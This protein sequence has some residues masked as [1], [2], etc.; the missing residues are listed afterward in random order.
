MSER[1]EC[2]HE[3]EFEDKPRKTPSWE[4]AATV[5]K[6]LDVSGPSKIR[7][8]GRTA[9]YC[10]TATVWD[11]HRL[12]QLLE[13][14]DVTTVY[15]LGAG[16][17]RVSIWLARQGYRV[18]AYELKHTLAAAARTEFTEP[19]LEI[20]ERDYYAD[21][22]EF[23]DDAAVVAFGGTNELPHI[24]DSGLAVEGYGEIGI[25]AHYDGE[26]VAVW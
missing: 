4:R 2:L 15:D 9:W 11:A 5:T 6:G 12:K 23:D 16:D 14:Y 8:T 17:C 21:F 19:D 24:P 22:D 25:R 10:P 7:D 3:F 1:R 26:L 18:I 13:A 20:R